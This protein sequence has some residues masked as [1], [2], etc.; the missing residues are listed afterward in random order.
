MVLAGGILAPP[1]TCSSCQNIPELQFLKSNIFYR[2]LNR[3][4]LSGSNLLLVTRISTYRKDIIFITFVYYWRALLSNHRFK[5]I[6]L[7]SAE[8]LDNSILFSTQ[9]LL[10][11]PNFIIFSS[12]EQRSGRAIVLPLVLASTNV[13]DFRTSLFPNPLMDLVHGLVWWWILVQN[14]MD[15]PSPSLYMTL[16]SRSQ[17]CSC[18]VTVP[19]FHAVH[20]HPVH[21]LKVRVMDLDFFLW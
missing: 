17:T 14:F 18:L 6:K 11:I 19:K 12:L 4:C 9:S 16:R 21:D 5:S 1:G 10:K 20:P 8:K 2:W 15:V 13:N 3:T 7:T